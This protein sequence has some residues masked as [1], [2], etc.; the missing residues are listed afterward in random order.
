MY[1][2]F[3]D[4]F[5]HPYFA[6]WNVV[7]N[8]YDPKALNRKIPS[9]FITE[10]EAPQIEVLKKSDLYICHGGINSVMEGISYKVKLVVL[11]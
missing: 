6:D 5:S 11:P 9:N 4:A 1:E 2:L 8:C 7:M 10:R 3:V